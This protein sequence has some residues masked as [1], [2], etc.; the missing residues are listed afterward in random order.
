MSVCIDLFE[1][2]IHEH[3]YLPLRSPSHDV[4]EPLVTHFPLVLLQLEPVQHDLLRA[5]VHRLPIFAHP[6][7][8]LNVG[9][10]LTVLLWIHTVK[11]YLFS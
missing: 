9:E 8:N 1:I 3:V 6:K 7:N 11:R 5:P 2:Q 10:N 4:A